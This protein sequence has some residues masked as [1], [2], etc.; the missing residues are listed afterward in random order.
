[1]NNERCAVALIFLRGVE[2]GHCFSAGKVPGESAFD[3]DQLVAQPNVGEGSAHHDFVIA[4]A[5]AVGVEVGGL[6]AVLLQVFS[7]GTIFLDGAGGTDVVGGHAVAKDGQHAGLLDF[8]DLGRFHR[9]LL[10]V[11]SAADVGGIF[12]PGVGFALWHGEA[13]PALVA[14]KDF[15]VTLGEHVGGDRLL[16]RF[17]DLALRRPDVGKIDGGAVAAFANGIL[18]QIG[19]DASGKREGDHQ[20]RRHQVIRANLGV[21]AAF[22]VA[23][24]GENGGD[25]QLLLVDGLRYFGGE[26]AGGA[27]AGP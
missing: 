22:K 6:H 12:F 10:E 2:D 19:V 27:D 21:D 14:L 11:R 26:R 23:I 5:R 13:A 3:V 20:R 15:A 16:N 9:H 17:L 1:M 25:H 4:A 18:A 7:G 24:A 8:L